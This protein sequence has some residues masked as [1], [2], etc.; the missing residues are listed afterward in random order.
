MCSLEKKNKNVEGK[1]KKTRPVFGIH[2]IREHF[3]WRRSGASRSSYIG[4][5]IS[6]FL[7]SLPFFCFSV[8]LE[9]SPVCSSPCVYYCHF[10]LLPSRER[11]YP[12]LHHVGRWAHTETTSRQLLCMNLASIEVTYIHTF[13]HLLSDSLKPSMK[14]SEMAIKKIKLKKKAK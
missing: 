8:L 10:S 6:G 2:C 11:R 4:A 3:L 7:F 12:T 14:K 13:H 5:V 1:E 9:C